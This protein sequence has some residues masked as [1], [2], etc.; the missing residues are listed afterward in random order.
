MGLPTRDFGKTREKLE[1]IC[2]RQLIYNLCELHWRPS[3]AFHQLT[4]RLFR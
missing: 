1:A 3:I 2:K 4:W